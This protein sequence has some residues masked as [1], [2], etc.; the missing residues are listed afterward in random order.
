MVQI[1][2]GVAT[3]SQNKAGTNCQTVHNYLGAEKI[4]FL[5][6]QPRT[7]LKEVYIQSKT[8]LSFDLMLGSSVPLFTYTISFKKI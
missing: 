3:Q 8:S 7:C 4:R 5:P 6:L 1:P 2:V